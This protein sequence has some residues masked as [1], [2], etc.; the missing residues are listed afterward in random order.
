[1]REQLISLAHQE[2]SSVNFETIIVRGTSG[3]IVG[4]ILAHLMS[5][6]LVV[7]RK[8]GE[9][10]HTSL[11]VSGYPCGRSVIVDDFIDSGNT[12]QIILNTIAELPVGPKSEYEVS[13]SDCT[14]VFG[15]YGYLNNWRD[16]IKTDFYRRKLVELAL[17][18]LNIELDPIFTV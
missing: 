18:N 12:V 14:N 1:M 11:S 9:S 7:V 15:F 16:K 4:P 3:L 8:K 10:S 6:N 17:T 13:K 2:L 5:K